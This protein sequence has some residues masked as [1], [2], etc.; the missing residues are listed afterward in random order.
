MVHFRYLF[1]LT[2]KKGFKCLIYSGIEDNYINQRTI[3]ITSSK[4]SSKIILLYLNK[5]TKK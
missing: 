1:V 5:N 3:K 2:G 4:I